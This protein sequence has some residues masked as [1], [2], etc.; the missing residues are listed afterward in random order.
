M[1]ASGWRAATIE[2][3]SALH[4]YEVLHSPTTLCS[5]C[6]FLKQGRILVRILNEAHLSRDQWAAGEIRPKVIGVVRLK[7]PSKTDA[8]VCPVAKWL[9]SFNGLKKTCRWYD[10]RS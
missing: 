4:R 3:A 9:G 2:A 10:S 5:G 1:R 8:A 7:G 6:G